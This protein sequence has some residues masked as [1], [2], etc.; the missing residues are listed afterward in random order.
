MV[1]KS[2]D[3]LHANKS[4]GDKPTEGPKGS[5]RAAEVN[6]RESRF[7]DTWW[8]RGEFMIAMISIH[9]LDHFVSGN[10]TRS[11]VLSQWGN[12][13]VSSFEEIGGLVLAFMGAASLIAILKPVKRVLVL[14]VFVYLSFAAIHLVVNVGAL[15]LTAELRRGEPLTQLADVVAVY[16]MGVFVFTAWYWFL[17][18]TTAEGAFVF[19][20]K[21]LKDSKGT[22]I[23]YLFL[24]FNTS[25]T[26]GPTVELPTTRAA[27]LLMMLQVCSSLVVLM[28]LLA[29]AI[30]G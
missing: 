19:P 3:N 11:G 8:Q 18:R 27:K 16:F 10:L 28:V 17:D 22:L 23:D 7:L 15:L 12:A 26:F 1:P 9:V 14:T 4:P 29:R 2:A 21:P 5:A 20:H 13:V 6:S 30:N 25:A 24:S